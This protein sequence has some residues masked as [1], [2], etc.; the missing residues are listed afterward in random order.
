QSHVELV[1]DHLQ[2]YRAAG[3]K[4]F[5]PDRDAVERRTLSEAAGRE[6]TRLESWLVKERRKPPGNSFPDLFRGHVLEA[7]MSTVTTRLVADIAQCHVLEIGSGDLLHRFMELG[8]PPGQASGIDPAPYGLVRSTAAADIRPVQAHPDDLPFPD[9]TFDLVVAV[10]YFMHVLDRHLQELIGNELRRVAKEDGI[11]LTVDL[12]PGNEL[13]LPPYY[14]Y[15]T[16]GIDIDDLERIFPDS[17]ID[18][19]PLT[20]YSVAVIRSRPPVGKECLP[21][22]V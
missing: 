5:L 7:A 19:E 21:D 15:T 20:D 10:G 3:W 14:A 8:L 2:W 4:S 11:I 22:G 16:A 1:A 17:G 6:K 12:T 18:Y 9:R 13:R